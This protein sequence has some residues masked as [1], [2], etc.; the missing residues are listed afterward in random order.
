MTQQNTKI[1]KVDL[2]NP[3]SSAIEQAAKAL[4]DGYPVIFPTD[5]VYGIGM[6]ALSGGDAGEIFDIK[7]RDRA[8]T[9]PWLV[10]SPDDL[11]LYGAD[12]PQSCIELANDHWPGAL[13]I[14]VKASEKVPPAYR[15]NDGT[16]A[17]RIPDSQIALAL[18]QACGLPLATT[19]ANI[20]GYPAAASVLDLDKNIVG[21]VA[22]LIDGGT[23]PLGVPS[24]IISYASGVPKLIREGSVK[25]PLPN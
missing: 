14:V 22:V 25:P 4:L 16:I 3:N 23:I 8:Q 5:T 2:N 12:L 7:C 13:T 24:T 6:A 10:S 21:K 9:L 11:A 15:A 20:H 18:I 1:L 19:S 17:L